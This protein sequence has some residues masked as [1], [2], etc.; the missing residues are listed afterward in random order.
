MIRRALARFRRHH[1]PCRWEIAGDPGGRVRLCITPTRL[2]D[3]KPRG[4]RASAPFLP[5][6]TATRG[7]LTHPRRL[8]PQP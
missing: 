3:L 4:V 8:H 6:A 2:I 1:G 5:S 7:S